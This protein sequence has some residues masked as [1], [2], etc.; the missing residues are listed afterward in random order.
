ME[1]DEKLHAVPQQEQGSQIDVVSERQLETETGAQ[2]VFNIAVQRLLSVNEWGNYA[3]VSAF[4][5]LD[6]HGVRAERQAEEG[7]YIRIDIPGPGAKAGKG[8]DWVRIEEISSNTTIAEP[9]VAMRVR[10]SAHPHADEAE[11]AHFLKDIAT[12]TFIIRKVGLVIYA[13]EHARNEVPNTDDVGLYDKGRNLI[14][15]IGAKLGLSY[16]QWKRLVNG[17]LS[18]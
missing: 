2:S 15:A 13:E 18:D 3:G 10:P 17:L 14:V 7:D 5:L 12:S 11:T 16:P 9:W 8:Y 1:K 6:E 4:Q